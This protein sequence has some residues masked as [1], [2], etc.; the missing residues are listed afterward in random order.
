MSQ[1]SF[2][3]H[4][5]FVPES[6]TAR[7]QSIL[8]PLPNDDQN[9]SLQSVQPETDSKSFLVRCELCPHHCVLAPNQRGICFGRQNING[10]LKTFNYGY[11]T[12]L[13][14]D[15]IEKKPLYHFLPNSRIL[16]IGTIGCNLSCRF[17]QNYRSS[18]AT[19]FQ[20]VFQKTAPKSL[21]E[22][23]LKERCP[24]VA[25]TY[26]EPTVWSEFVIDAAL[27]CRNVGLKT[28]AVTNGMIASAAREEFYQVMDAVNIDLKG[29]SP[30]FYRHLTGG[31]LDDVKETI[32]YVAQKTEVWLE[33]TNLLIP[34]KNDDSHE[35]DQM[36]RWIADVV[37]TEVPLHFSA[38]F[39]TYLMTNLPKTPPE[40]LFQAR[41]IALK[42]GLKFVYCGNIIDPNGHST[43]C[44]HCGSIIIR[45]NGYSNFDNRV[46]YETQNPDLKQKYSV[47]CP[48]CGY[49]IAG[50]F[51]DKP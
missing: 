27:E 45:R 20:L 35:I 49:G 33:I 16:S 19:D 1:Y 46:V 24:S 28:V 42:N 18:K 38:F 47:F 34:G 2:V 29:F 23:A 11:H 31:N 36:T 39:P 26:N 9:N 8:P 41:E 14:I 13:S 4:R 17:C 15:P 22:I 50:F 44:P 43:F 3:S 40:I 25:F 12:G 51:M 7:W 21:A 5:N 37:G 10:I 6:R 32:A 30:E 48:D